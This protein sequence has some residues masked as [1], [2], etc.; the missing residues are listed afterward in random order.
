VEK[1]FKPR[2]IFTRHNP[3]ATVRNLSRERLVL[4]DGEIL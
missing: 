3:L 1:G 2:L 4:F